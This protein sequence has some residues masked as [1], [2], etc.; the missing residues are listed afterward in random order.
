MHD[1]FFSLKFL[2]RY[3]FWICFSFSESPLP[4][5][6]KNQMVNPKFI[7]NVRDVSLQIRYNY[8]FRT[9]CFTW[10]FIVYVGRNFKKYFKKDKYNVCVFNPKKVLPEA[11]HPFLG[12][13]LLVLLDV[14]TENLSLSK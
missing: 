3:S 7:C 1:I 13:M 14:K 8:I 12:D 10:N 2:Y 6:L 5:P 9:Q 11:Y 4:P